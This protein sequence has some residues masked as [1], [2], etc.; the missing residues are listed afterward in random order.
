[1][2]GLMPW[3][4]VVTRADF[5]LNMP[6]QNPLQVPSIEWLGGTLAGDQ[7]IWWRPAM[8]RENT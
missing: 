6:Q 7:E 3:K 4:A 2:L 5:Q 1:M 8:K